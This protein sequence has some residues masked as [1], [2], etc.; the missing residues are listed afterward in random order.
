MSYY[1]L[2][3]VDLGDDV[4]LCQDE[5][6]MLE[7]SQSDVDYLWQDGSTASEFII[8][9]GGAYN[10]QLTNVCGSVSDTILASYTLIPPIELG[11][12][13]TLC[14]GE[15]I[16]LDAT[17]SGATYLWQNNST[18]AS[19]NTNGTGSYDVMV[20]INNCSITDN[21]FL[22]EELCESILLIPNIFSPNN[23]GMND[24]FMPLKSEGVFNMETIIYNRWGGEVF[25]TN[26]LDIGWTGG[27]VTDG[28]Y[29][30]IISYSGYHGK[31]LIANGTVSLFR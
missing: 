27:D 22:T 1:T 10:V 11:N 16:T 20:T 21:L 15:F 12:D 6:Y 5:S 24:V 3:T 8:I 31:N 14:Q 23:D 18:N 2:P 19:I 28:V 13:T 29:F 4:F 30:Y 25:E 26:Q 7:L 17:S 9:E